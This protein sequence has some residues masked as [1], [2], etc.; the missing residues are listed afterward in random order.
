MIE[1]TITFFGI[2]S[3]LRI[4]VHSID[5][6][7]TI[8]ESG[9]NVMVDWEDGWGDAVAGEAVTGSLAELLGIEEEYEVIDEEVLLDAYEE[10]A[11][12]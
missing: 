12:E 4:I 2:D 9:A 3:T 11:T 5:A 8:I 6:L 7:R 1:Y 10:A